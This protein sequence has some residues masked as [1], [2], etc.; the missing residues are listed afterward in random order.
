[1]ML[2]YESRSREEVKKEV[3]GKA[4]ARMTKILGVSLLY[5]S[6]TAGIKYYDGH[7]S[8][9]LEQSLVSR[10]NPNRK[11]P[12]VKNHKD[13]TEEVESLLAEIPR[14]FREYSYY[15]TYLMNL[16]RFPK[17]INAKIRRYNQLISKKQDIEWSPKVMAYEHWNKKRIDEFSQVLGSTSQFLANFLPYENLI[18]LGSG[19]YGILKGRKEIKSFDS[20]F[21]Q[22]S[23]PITVGKN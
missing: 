5:L 18:I 13:L 2:Q 22:D 11:E 12:I 1:M 7:R 3:K 14:D 23:L 4:V 19:I 20:E 16:H 8:S 9:S 10:I 17:E 15:P 6:L 21:S